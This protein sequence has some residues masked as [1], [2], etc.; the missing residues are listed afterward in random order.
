MAAVGVTKIAIG[1]NTGRVAILDAESLAPLAELKPAA[2]ARLW[3]AVAGVWPE[4]SAIR[5]LRMIPRPHRTAPVLLAALRADCHLQVWDLSGDAARGGPLRPTS[6]LAARLPGSPD[7]ATIGGVDRSG[8]DGSGMRSRE[9]RAMHVA[10]GFLAAAISG[11][12]ETE[13]DPRLPRRSSIF[14]YRLDCS[15]PAPPSVAFH[16]EVK[17]SEGRHAEV[18]VA[19]GRVWSLDASGVGDSPAGLSRRAR[20]VAAGPRRAR[21]P[22]RGPRRRRDGARG[23]DGARRGGAGGGA[24]A[25]ESARGFGSRRRGGPRERASPRGVAGAEAAEAA[26]RGAGIPH[27]SGAVARD[28]VGA[29]AAAI[30]RA[31][32]GS[33]RRRKRGGRVVGGGGEYASS[34]AALRRPTGF[35]DAGPKALALVRG[36]GAVSVMRPLEPVEA[37]VNAPSRRARRSSSARRTCASSRRRRRPRRRRWRRAPRSTP[38]SAPRA[39]RDG[40]RRARRGA[41]RRAGGRTR[42]SMDRFAIL[43]GLGGRRPRRRSGGR[44]AFTFGVCHLR[45]LWTTRRA[46]R[47]ESAARGTAPPRGRSAPPSPSA[48]AATRRAWR[49]AAPRRRRARVGPAPSRLPLSWVRVLLLDGRGEIPSRRAAV[50][51]PRPGAPRDRPLARRDAARRGR[52]LGRVARRRRRAA[53]LLPRAAAALRDA[54]LAAWLA[55]TPRTV[56]VSSLEGETRLGFSSASSLAA[57]ARGWA[58]A[59]AAL[60]GSASHLTAAASA[61]A[62]EVV[63]GSDNAAAVGVPRR[64][65]AVRGNRRRA[66]RRRRGGRARDPA[67]RRATRHAGGPG[68]SRAGR[69]GARV[70]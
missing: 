21:V 70:P 36:T 44:R 8:G 51:R 28:P 54:L 65:R 46:R 14:L 49:R 35:A 40:P 48:A 23:V 69:A 9:A 2:L 19:D 6:V 62:A 37:F 39:A 45:G 57:A 41:R 3:N 31:A 22:V 56:G 38:R 59:P 13:E 1:G 25:G 7:A 34:W 11:D 20:A 12:S 53:A 16:A 42:L 29:V 68:G 4:L 18:R 15:G 5:G 60:S 33:A 47:C 67:Q 63:V 43:G 64:V 27:D 58:P 66:L 55:S 52:G 10:D 24:F 30:V 61:L 17:G 32:G 26:L 50:P